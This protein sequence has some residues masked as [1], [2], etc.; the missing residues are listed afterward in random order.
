MEAGRYTR[1]DGAHRT[2]IQIKNPAQG[3]GFSLL[4]PGHH[5]PQ[6]RPDLFYR[7]GGV[8]ISQV[9][10]FPW[11]VGTPVVRDYQRA[12]ASETGKE[13]YSFTSLEGYIAAKVLVEGLRRAGRDLTRERLV[14]ALETLVDYDAGGFLVNYSPTDHGGSR[15][16][17]LTAIGR[18]GAFVR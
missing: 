12:L 2:A 11:N 6:F 17:E 1:A 14:A 10:P 5:L 3:A 18:D 8:G 15:Y 16:V 13:S 4:D 7:V 9:V